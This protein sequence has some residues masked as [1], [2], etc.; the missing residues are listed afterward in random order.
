MRTLAAVLTLAVAA[1]APA[2]IRNVQLLGTFDPG[3]PS[4]GVWGYVDVSTGKEYAVLLSLSGTRIFDCTS[5]SPIQ[6]AYFAGPVSN[7]REARAYGNHIYVV[8]EGGGGMQVIDMTSPDTPQLLGTATTSGWNNT[9]NIGV[10]LERGTVWACGTNM[11]MLVFDARANPG[12]PPLIATLNSPYVHDVHVQDGL[13]HVS[14]IF[15]NRYQIYDVRNLP[16]I[17]LVG[18]ALAPGRRYFHNSWATRDSSYSVGTNETSGG[19]LSVWDI[20][21]PALPLLAAQIHPA[22]ATAAIH[23]AYVRDRVVHIAYYTEGYVA[24]D[25]ANP[26]QPVVVGQYDTYAGTSTGFNGAWGCFP[27][28]PSGRVFVSDIPTGLYVLRPSASLVRYG[29][30][31]PGGS[32]RS[33]SAFVTGSAY[34]GN[35]AFRFDA[36]R[37]VANSPGLLLINVARLNLNIA[38]LQLNVDPFSA[39]A[40]LVAV[41]TDGNGKISVPAPVPNVPQMAGSVLD[42]QFFVFDPGGPFSM[43]ASQGIE[44]TLFAQ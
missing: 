43:S 15:G 12:N 8:T 35:P 1:V 10:D 32:G 37:A 28:L 26:A 31:T 25:I 18:Q 9:H 38:G 2:Q 14:D 39:S 44:I 42:A 30:V 4:S 3:E 7:W 19:P 29:A 41:A 34:L 36:D 20:R 11:G 17:T 33:P 40:V 5:G 13:A 27:F 21:N 16:A 24:V 22:P 6:R 23:N